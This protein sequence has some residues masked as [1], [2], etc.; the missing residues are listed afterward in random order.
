MGTAT[1]T[2]SG[3]WQV[4]RGVNSVNVVCWGN[5][6]QGNKGTGV[7][8]GSG[9]GGGAYAS[10]TT[11]AVVPGTQCTITKVAGE[12]GYF[13]FKDHNGTVQVQ[14]ENGGNGALA[15]G[16]PP[17]TP[18]PGG[19]GGQAAN[20]VGAVKRSGG[21]GGNCN[22]TDYWGGGGGG[23]GAFSYQDG[24]PGGNGTY[25][26]DGYGGAASGGTSGADG[27]TYGLY[28]GDG[29]CGGGGGATSSGGGTSNGG[30]G[31]VVITFA[32]DTNHAVRRTQI[33]T[34]GGN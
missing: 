26:T 20:C 6:G 27:L 21:V 23:G 11:I 22:R 30:A 9:G 8:P 13:Q 12:G 1:F 5:G 32:G 19:P 17:A 34:A 29:G 33:F 25:L 16:P 4:P 28:S 31:A 18:A 3:T 14:A 24:D 10:R 2:A 7:R 15:S